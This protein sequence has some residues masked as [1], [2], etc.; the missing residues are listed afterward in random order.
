MTDK[1]LPPTA[2]HDLPSQPV[3]EGN[4]FEGRRFELI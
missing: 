2:P 1:A 4:W 3:R